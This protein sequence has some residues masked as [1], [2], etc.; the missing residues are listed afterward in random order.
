MRSYVEED[1][2]RDEK[3]FAG[4]FGVSTTVAARL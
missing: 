2:Q 3:T 1:E 4:V